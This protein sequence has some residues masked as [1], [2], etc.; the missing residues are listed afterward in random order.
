[1]KAIAP[2]NWAAVVADVARR[3]RLHQGTA[4]AV[5]DIAHDRLAAALRAFGRLRVPGLGVFTV[6]HRKARNIRNPQTGEMMRLPRQ[7]YVHFRAERG[8]DL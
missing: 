3:N 5:L 4:R 7:R 1:M 8:L 6:R 2:A